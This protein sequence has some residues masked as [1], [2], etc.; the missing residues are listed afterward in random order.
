MVVE[1]LFIAN[2]LSQER[3]DTHSAPNSPAPGR[4]C[5]ARP[6]AETGQARLLGA[7]SDIVK[8]QFSAVHVLVN[9]AGFFWQLGL[10]F[11]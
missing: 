5:Q 7:L 10:L 8:A 3:A 11:A 1:A 2:F 9:N 6:K 4:P